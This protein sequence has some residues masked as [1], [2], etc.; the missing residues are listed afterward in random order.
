[1]PVLEYP[2]VQ[3]YKDPLNI[4]SMDIGALPIRADI[5]SVTQFCAQQTPPITLVSFTKDPEV[6]TRFSND[7]GRLYNYYD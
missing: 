6:G 2:L 3:A 7:G 1:M 5:V 4:N